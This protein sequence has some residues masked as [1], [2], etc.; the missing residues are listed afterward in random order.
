M[1]KSAFL[2]IF[3]LFSVAS[4]SAATQIVYLSCDLP[5]EDGSP[6]THFDFTLDEQNSTVSFYVEKAGIVNK[7]KALFGPQ[8]VTW[9]SSLMGTTLTRTINR[10]DLSF[11]QELN[12]AGKRSHT[13]GQCS[14]VKTPPRQF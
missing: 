11:I 14:L 8:T 5:G 3:L 1:G 7:E 4:V 10:T 2:A 9:T 12:I 6:A 13:T